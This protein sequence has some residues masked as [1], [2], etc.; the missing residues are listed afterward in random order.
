MIKHCYGQI[1]EYGRPVEAVVSR[2]SSAPTKIVEFSFAEIF[3]LLEKDEV[4]RKTLL[5]LELIGRPLMLRQMADILNANEADLTERVA[6]LVI[7]RVEHVQL[8]EVS[9]LPP[10]ERGT[11]GFG[12]TGA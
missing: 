9:E 4:Q 8:T 11:G 2:L 7:Q 3:N 1:F 6:Q 10:S 12:S 5:L